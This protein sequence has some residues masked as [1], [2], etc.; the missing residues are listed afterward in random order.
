[1]SP[2]VGRHPRTRLPLQR[3]RPRLLFHATGASATSPA[4]AGANYIE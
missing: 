1:M 2:P 3:V 4:Q